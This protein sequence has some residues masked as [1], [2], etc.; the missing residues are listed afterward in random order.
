METKR[1]PYDE[2]R[3]YLTR[4]FKLD[5]N[6]VNEPLSGKLL[7]ITNTDISWNNLEFKIFFKSI[8]EDGNTIIQKLSDSEGYDALSYCWGDSNQ[9]FPLRVSSIGPGLKEKEVLTEH[10][11]ERNG[12]LE[13]QPSLHALLVQLRQRK[14]NHFIW[15]DAI[16]IDQNNPLD[17]DNQI[18]I[19]RDIYE[20]A[21]CVYVWLDEATDL[22]RGAF[23]IMPLLTEK[24]LAV[25]ESIELDPRRSLSFEKAGLPSTTHEVWNAFGTILTR[26]WWTRLWTLQEVVVAKADPST[27]KKDLEYYPPNAIILCGE[28]TTQWTIFE[29]FTSAISRLGLEEWI[30]TGRQGVTLDCRHGF[31]A[32]MEIRTCRESYEKY[33]WGVSLSALLLATRLRKATIPV[34]VV[35]GQSALLDKHT[36]KNLALKSSQTAE[37]VFTAFAKHY[38]RQEPKECLLN[39]IATR[40]RNST[41]PS[42]CPN[43]ASPPATTSLGSRWLGHYDSAKEQK[44]QMYH[45]GFTKKGKWQIPRSKLYYAKYVTNAGTGRDSKLNQ[46]N[47]HNPRQIQLIPNSDSILLSGIELDEVVEVISPN[48]ATENVK[49]LAFNSIQQTADWD[50][51]CLALARKTLP[52]GA[53]GFDVYARTLTANRVVMYPN[54][55]TDK[56]F[57]PHGELDFVAPYLGLKRFVQATL[58]AGESISEDGNVGRDVLRYVRVLER[59]TKHRSFFA[60]K[61]GRIGIGPSDA[62]VGDRLVVA[63]YC[64]TPYLIRQIEADTRFRIAGEVYVHGLMYGEALEM[65][66][67]GE[68]QESKWVIT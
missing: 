44:A 42:W 21:E 7:S 58:D 34:D 41:L 22:E 68:V 35:I 32:I 18:P 16:C 26:P 56:V 40:E 49:L 61:R 53:E 47:T 65:F 31:D 2:P 8:G 5:L 57:D 66:D 48:P 1:F 24:L 11:P 12:I 33:G 60:T 67:K 62:Q 64:P 29:R 50:S 13:I 9:R 54:S 15:I 63:F 43:F 25:E 52:S 3:P 20:Y 38:I 55:Q 28:T 30:L 14:Y 51:A 4:L 27:K 59:I 45:A 23:Q 39:H 46:Y 10:K 17:K 36:M 6:G 37:Y 19:M